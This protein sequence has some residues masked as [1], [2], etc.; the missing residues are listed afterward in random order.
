[1]IQEEVVFLRDE[2]G[3]LQSVIVDLRGQLT[4]AQ[5]RIAELEQQQ[6]PPAPKS[7]PSFVKPNRPKRDTTPDGKR[8]KRAPQHN[9][10]RRR[11]KPTRIECHALDRC[12]VCAYPLSGESIDYTRQ[13]IEI[14]PPPPVEITEHRVIK[15]K[16]PHCN[17]WRSPHLDLSQQVMGQGR[18]GV[19]I[20]SL[21]SYLRTAL[22][23]TVRSIQTYLDTLHGLSLSS[24]EIVELTHR[25]RTASTTTI[26][27]LKKEIRQSPVIHGDE[28]GWREDGQNGYV[29][30][31]TTPGPMGI[32]YYAYDHSRGQAVADRLLKDVRAACLVT[33]FY[34]GY[35]NY[36]G[37]QQRCWVH[38]L[39]ALHD[40]K[41]D[42]A[43]DMAVLTWAGNV[44]R[45]YDDAHAWQLA[46]PAASVAERAALYQTLVNGAVALGRHYAQM[47]DDPCNAL[48]KRL[49][50]HQDELFQFVIR[51]GVSADN[52][53]AER[54]IRPL[55][56]I[57]KISGGTRSDKGTET[58]L[59]LASLFGTW[60]VRGLNPFVECFRLLS[61]APP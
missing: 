53:L 42:H 36:V 27:D 55:V 57:R 41:E 29:W 58:R 51:D 17:A 16:C 7:P 18:M 15:R 11:E 10:A 30:S 50:R 21:V 56:I 14:P 3:H 43:Q 46:H 26:D 25:V 5:A 38:L 13:V 49:L 37:P 54:T 45:L 35:N 22:R 39:R 61:H 12:P 32:R 1:M 44:R 52:N 47:Y 31:L 59:G 8:R 9:A 48:A 23:L 60:Y 28:T 4:V 33:D 19:R 20:A 40:L 2:V 6:K 34:C 24:G